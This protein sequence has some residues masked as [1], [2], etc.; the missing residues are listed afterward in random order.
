[1]KR[2]VTALMLMTLALAIPAALMAMDSDKMD[3]AATNK[4][5]E[6]GQADGMQMGQAMKM[7]SSM[8]DDAGDFVEVGSDS[9][10]GVAAM[11]KVKTYDEK[12][13]AS[14]QKMGM[15]ATHHVMVFFTDEA[16]GQ[17]LGGQAALKIKDADGNVSEPAMMMR[18]GKGFGA[19]VQQL[20]P[21]Q[22]PGQLRW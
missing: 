2:I 22:R 4:A 9:V 8:S 20:V 21:A 18:M 6:M 3:R 12:T 19:G 15:N 10:D 13:L 14:M 5:A 17:A 7:G 16:S 1:M 11:V